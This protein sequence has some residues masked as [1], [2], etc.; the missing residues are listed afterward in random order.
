[1]NKD[2]INKKKGKKD[3][4]GPDAAIQG[5]ESLKSTQ[6]NATNDGKLKQ[7]AVSQQANTV[8]QPV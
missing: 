6:Y 1:M 2:K 8:T 3:R 7:S 4:K 5:D